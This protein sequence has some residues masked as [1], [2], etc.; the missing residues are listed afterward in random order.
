MERSAST[1]R[2]TPRSVGAA[3]IVRALLL[4]VIA[5]PAAPRSAR[6]G[7]D[8]PDPVITAEARAFLAGLEKDGPEATFESLHATD[9]DPWVLVEEL[10]FLGRKEEALQLARAGL[11]S[12]GP[13]LVGYIEGDPRPSPDLAREA[14]GAFA[15]LDANEPAKVLEVLGSD[16]GGGL[17]VTDVQ[18]LRARAAALDALD[19]K[20]EARDV[21]GRMATGATALGWRRAAMDASMRILNRLDLDR[22]KAAGRRILTTLLSLDAGARDLGRSAVWCST[23]GRLE[24][25]LGSPSSAQRWLLEAESLFGVLATSPGLSP[26]LAAER[27]RGLLCLSRVEE[28]LGQT[29]AGIRAA[30]KAKDIAEHMKAD[31]RI[32]ALV[33]LCLAYEQLGRLDAAESQLEEAVAI[34]HAEQP[35]REPALRG[36]LARIA[37]DQGRVEDARKEYEEVR[38][39]LASRAQSPLSFVIREHL[40]GVDLNERGGMRTSADVRRGLQ[41]L[42]RVRQDLEALPPEFR[43]REELDVNAVIMVAQALNLLGR[44]S[45]AVPLLRGVADSAY[46]RQTPWLERSISVELCHALR[47]LGQGKAALEVA[48]RAVAAMRTE[49]RSLSE[50][51]AMSRLASP[52]ETRLIMEYVTCARAMGDPRLVVQA[53]EETRGTIFVQEQE[54]RHRAG[55]GRASTSRV[56]TVTTLASRVADA[57]RAYWR[58]VPRGSIERRNQARRELWQLRRDLRAARDRDELEAAPAGPGLPP[59]PWTHDAGPDAGPDVGLESGEAMLYYARTAGAWIAVCVRDGG[60]CGVYEIGKSGELA[61]AMTALRETWL[62]DPSPEKRRE[63]LGR[64]A[65]VLVPRKLAGALVGGGGKV[66]PVR[67]VYVSSGPL[68]TQV[69]WPVILEAALAD[70]TGATVSL[71]ASQGVLTLVRRWNRN[72]GDERILAIG[73]PE[74]ETESARRET[75][76]IFGRRLRALPGSAEE[77]RGIVDPAK[78]DLMLR[79]RDASEDFL[80]RAL[81]LGPHPWGCLH[82]SCHGILYGATPWM[83]A[84]ALHPSLGDDGLVTVEEVSQWSLPWG[85]WLVVL[86]A[87]DSGLGSPVAGEGEEGLVRAFLLAGARNVVASFWKVPDETSRDLMIAFHRL[88]RT[89]KLGPVQALRAAQ[90]EVRARAKH[91]LLPVDWAGWAVWG[92]RD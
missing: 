44:E 46:V 57:A 76:T 6:A 16:V 50:G 29:A 83:S 64:L 61:P 88:R 42:L 2:S 51:Y 69:P 28:E 82:L 9:A 14:A 43:R 21:L 40:A 36:D 89:E 39:A 27:F 72:T 34:A 37:L 87:C 56:S 31:K 30:H 85:P 80:R 60:A 79:G 49:V 7:D 78:G 71:I 92:P 8:D 66:G 24:R 75:M 25:D 19:R 74:Y 41:K 52:L 91:P 11:S 86:S 12:D 77:V 15:A 33:A 45:E 17:T 59:A 84:L 4:A 5:V 13:A 81:F 70:G 18:A 23:L 53:L 67:H 73:D 22:E 3:W 38:L 35:E 1:P 10:L 68:P 90:A 20:R 63:A 54:R 32:L 47:T 26:A 65:R 58:L 55:V 62:E 48:K